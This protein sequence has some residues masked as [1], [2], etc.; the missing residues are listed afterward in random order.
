MSNPII[1][2]THTRDKLKRKKIKL[3][4]NVYIIINE[5]IY[6]IYSLCDSRFSATLLPLA[7]WHVKSS[8]GLLILL[9][10]AMNKL[11]LL[12]RFKRSFPYSFLVLS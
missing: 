6:L 8:S 12:Q 9:P 1:M 7:V 4:V 5:Y 10:F 11:V 3:V 2:Y